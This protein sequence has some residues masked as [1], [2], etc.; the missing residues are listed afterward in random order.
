MPLWFRSQTEVILY[1]PP[2]RSATRGQSAVNPAFSTTDNCMQLTRLAG[3]G[4]TH[5]RKQQATNF[6]SFFILPLPGYNALTAC[7]KC[8]S[9]VKCLN[10]Q[11]I[12]LLLYAFPCP[13]AQR[14][15]FRQLLA[16]KIREYLFTN[17]G[18]N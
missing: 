9:N 11:I 6:L 2:Q 4:K 7:F 1:F 18:G 17:R 12:I 5:G 15:R 8:L 16:N 10:I 13:S 3:M 14:I